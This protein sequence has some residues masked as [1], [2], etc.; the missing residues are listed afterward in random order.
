MTQDQPLATC[1]H[2]HARGLGRIQNVDDLLGWESVPFLGCERG[3]S[4]CP[5]ERSRL[6]HKPAAGDGKSWINSRGR[7][8]MEA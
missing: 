5:Q 4:R 7:V 6:E 3:G 2:A 1:T 8:C